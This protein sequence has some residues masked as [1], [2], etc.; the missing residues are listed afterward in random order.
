LRILIADDHTLVRSSLAAMLEAQA[1]LQ[2]VGEAGTGQEACR[3]ASELTPDIVL[4][5]V[6]MPDG[7]GVQ[8]TEKIKQQMPQVRV[9]A[10]TMHED[11]SYLRLLLEAGASGY[12]LKR[13]ESA[14]LIHAIHTVAGG[15]TYLDPRLSD[16]VAQSLMSGGRPSLRGEIQGTALSEREEA[17]I[18]LLAQGYTSKEVGVKLSL[19]QKTVDTYKYRAMEKLELADRPAIFR[20]ALAQGWLTTA[21]PPAASFPRR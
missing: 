5:D 19:S 15:G 3:L 8:A 12:V 16:V 7:T 10:L 13:S 14:E 21:T 1:E 2:V 17:V 4:M 20:Y 11:R 6:S 18:R 9:I